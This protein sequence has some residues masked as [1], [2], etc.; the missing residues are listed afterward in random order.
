MSFANLTTRQK[1]LQ[2]LATIA[3]VSLQATLFCLW[4]FGDLP[5]AGNVFLGLVSTGAV[6]CLM[7]NCAYIVDDD[8]KMDPRTVP[9]GP[10]IAWLCLIRL[11]YMLALLFVGAFWI[12]ALYTLHVIVAAAATVEVYKRHNA[13]LRA[14]MATAEAQVPGLKDTVDAMRAFD[15]DQRG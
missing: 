6:L 8:S 1:I 13:K 10:K 14:E 15:R 7:A 5:E 12:Y 11:T 2:G 3:L 9:T 4:Q